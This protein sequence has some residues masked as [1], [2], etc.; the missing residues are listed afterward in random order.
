MPSAMRTIVGICIGETLTHCDCTRRQSSTMRLIALS[1][2]GFSPGFL[3][4][5]LSWHLV[6]P[7]TTPSAKSPRGGAAPSQ[8]VLQFFRSGRTTVL[9]PIYGP[10]TLGR[11]QRPRPS[12]TNKMEHCAGPV[13]EVVAASCAS[14]RA[15][16]STSPSRM[17]LQ[18]SARSRPTCTLGAK[19]GLCGGPLLTPC[20]LQSRCPGFLRPA[21]GIGGWSMALPCC[22]SSGEPIDATAALMLSFDE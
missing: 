7:C 2:E 4:A 19:H 10:R 17:R 14:L 16:W 22:S 9:H 6:W 5:L 12:S 20:E 15:M 8:A 3:Y 21:S 13:N 1:R 18:S 11:T